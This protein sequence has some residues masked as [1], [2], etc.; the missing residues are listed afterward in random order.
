MWGG[1][2]PWIFPHLF[3]CFTPGAWECHGNFMVMKWD[4]NVMSMGLTMINRD[5]TNINGDLLV[6]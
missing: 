5:F 4:F 3:V 6:T 1:F 2:P